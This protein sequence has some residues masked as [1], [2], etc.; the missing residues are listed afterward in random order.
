MIL[1]ATG[2]NANQ[3]C[4]QARLYCDIVDR[5]EYVREALLMASNIMSS[6]INESFTLH[7]NDRINVRPNGKK[8]NEEAAKTYGGDVG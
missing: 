2:D 5:D 7:K 6:S 8:V 3:V 4:V 1:L